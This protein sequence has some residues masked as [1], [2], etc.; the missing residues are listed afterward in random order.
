MS[1]IFLTGATGY[2]GGDVLLVSSSAVESR[3]LA[4]FMLV[5]DSH[6]VKQ[7]SE[8]YPGVEIIQGDLDDS[9]LLEKEARNAD[10]VLSPFS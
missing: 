3:Q 5:R 6:K 10:V 8:S 9:N 2:V 4:P 7:L 1:R